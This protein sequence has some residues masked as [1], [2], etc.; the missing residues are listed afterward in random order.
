MYA[1][2]ASTSPQPKW[3]FGSWLIPP[4]SV[5]FETVMSPAFAVVE[6]TCF[7]SAICLTSAGRADQR[8]ATTPTTCGAAIE[9]PE[10]LV[11]QESVEL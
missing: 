8:S 1:A 7:V 9:V 10:R 11:Y 5:P 3:L 4:H 6:R 2:S